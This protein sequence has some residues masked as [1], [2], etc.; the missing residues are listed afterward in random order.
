MTGGNGFVV[1]GHQVGLQNGRNSESMRI[2]L[3]AAA[4]LAVSAVA[5]LASV[6][7]K[8]STSQIEWARLRDPQAR[9][10]VDVPT[11]WDFAA[12]L[13]YGQVAEFRPDSTSNLIVFF[14]RVEPLNASEYQGFDAWIREEVRH[15]RLQGKVLKQEQMVIGGRRAAR[16]ETLARSPRPAYFVYTYIGVPDSL[17][18]PDSGVMFM[19]LLDA[20]S[21]AKARPLLA[22]YERM[23]STLEV[24]PETQ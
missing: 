7:A 23:L 3:V 1:A 10:A 19:F 4:G 5:C 12:T 6:P 17:A 20:P 24:L 21:E 11:T 14:G 9:V 15:L 22:T 18:G 2:P 16:I 8:D 13:P